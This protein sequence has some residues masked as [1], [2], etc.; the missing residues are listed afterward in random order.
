MDLFLSNPALFCRKK[1]DGRRRK[2]GLKTERKTGWGKCVG[3]IPKSGMPVYL[4]T[5]G[6]RIQML[7]YPQRENEIFLHNAKIWALCF[8]FRELY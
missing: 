1:I 8:L 7:D 5:Y 6:L 4:L 3:K 2:K